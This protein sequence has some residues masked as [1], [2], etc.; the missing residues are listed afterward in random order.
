MR[1]DSQFDFPLRLL[2][3]GGG[4]KRKMPQQLNWGKMPQQLNWGKMP[5]PLNWGKMPQQRCRQDVEQLN[6]G[7]MPQQ[8]CRQDAPATV[9]ARCP[10][11]DNQARISFTTRP[12]TSV[13]R[14]S[15]P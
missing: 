13:R 9:P 8:R 12:C 5:Q 10:S 3:F 1:R 4:W 7:R 15:R 14:K 2:R 11:N 6:W